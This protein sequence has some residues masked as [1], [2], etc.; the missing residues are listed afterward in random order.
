MANSAKVQKEERVWNDPPIVT[1]VRPI[2]YKTLDQLRDTI[3]SHLKENPDAIYQFLLDSEKAR[4]K[5]NAYMIGFVCICIAVMVCFSQALVPE[6]TFADITINLLI[7]SV[8]W[9]GI[10]LFTR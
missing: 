3:A 8:V 2:Q 5:A 1:D 4:R 9:I 7:L 10:G 6:M